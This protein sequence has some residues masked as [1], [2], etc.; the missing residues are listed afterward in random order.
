MNFKTQDNGIPSKYQLC[1][2]RRGRYTLVAIIFVLGGCSLSPDYIRPNVAI[3]AW[4]G[5][6][7]SPTIRIAADWWSSFGSS[8]LD[9]L[10]EQALAYNNNLQASLHRV[11]QARADVQM[12]GA[13]LLPSASIAATTMNGPVQAFNITDRRNK[14]V[15][16]VTLDGGI[17]YELDLFGANRA[18]A[19]A[20]QAGLFGAQYA[21]DALALI[22]MGDIAQ[23]Y[24]NVL[25]LRE[26]EQIAQNNLNSVRDTSRLIEDRFQIGARTGLDIAQQKAVLSNTE[27]EL[28]TIEQQLAIAQNV[29]AVLVG[30]TPQTFSVST[31]SLNS[32]IIPPLAVL[33]PAELLQRR[34]DIR[35]AEADL[36][37]ANADIGAVRAAFYPKI[38]LGANLLAAFNP[39]ATTLAVTAALDAPFFQGGRLEGRLNR[40]KARQAELAENYQQTVLVSF[41]EA[42][43]ALAR[44]KTT[45][46]REEALNRSAAT[47]REA[48]NIAQKQYNLSVLDFQQSLDA[49]RLMLQADDAY[50]RARFETIA[51]RIDVFKAMG[52]GWNEVGEKEQY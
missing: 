15:P 40:A 32:I 27:A 18:N 23:G 37:A 16:A 42:E 45:Q 6:E 52:G 51:A 25:N 46:K 33:Q 48:Y 31:H 17:S 28:A 14:D 26:R 43:D 36:I 30:E 35:S 12:A 8:E 10:M 29:L 21:Y 7:N 11:E 49:Q 5:A 50:A 47:A 4:R 9:T 20:A 34:P 44:V 41:R 13:S 38:N 22:V 3:P 1:P 24:F 2:Q 39:A 19:D